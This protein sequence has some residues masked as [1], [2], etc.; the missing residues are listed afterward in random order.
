MSSR[1]DRSHAPSVHSDCTNPIT[2]HLGGLLQRFVM[3]DPFQVSPPAFSYILA[4]RSSPSDAPRRISYSL[5]LTA[6]V[7]SCPS[8][9]TQPAL[10]SPLSVLT[11]YAQLSR[12]PFIFTKKSQAAPPKIITSPCGGVPCGPFTA[13][14]PIIGRI[15]RSSFAYRSI[16]YSDSHEIRPSDAASADSHLL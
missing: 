16:L 4:R 1:P 3:Q 7:V 2:L 6:Y 11:T 14:A 15:A 12:Y 5:S 8:R 9:T 10:L 13:S